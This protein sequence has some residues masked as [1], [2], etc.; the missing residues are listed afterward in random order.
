MPR[1]RRSTGVLRTGL[2]LSL[3]RVVFAIFSPS[4]AEGALGPVYRLHLAAWA[5]HPLSCPALFEKIFRF[6]VDPT[7][8]YIL[9]IL[10]RSWIASLRWQ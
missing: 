6:A 10:A 9:C 8:I 5:N 2:D 3:H 7:R 1:T 4:T